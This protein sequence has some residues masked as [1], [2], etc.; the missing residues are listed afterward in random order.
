[1]A[2]EKPLLQVWYPSQYFVTLSQRFVYNYRVNS[3]KDSRRAVLSLDFV[4]FRLPVGRLLVSTEARSVLQKAR[5][6]MGTR[7]YDLTS[8]PAAQGEDVPVDL[9]DRCK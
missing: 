8:W 9:R 7:S 6:D 4:R 2:G 1:M 5:P 3:A